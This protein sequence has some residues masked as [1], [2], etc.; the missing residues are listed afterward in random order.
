MRKDYDLALRLH[1]IEMQLASLGKKIADTNLAAGSEAYV[2]ALTLHKSI[3]AAVKVNIPGAKAFAAELD[4][5]FV[6]KGAAPE[7]PA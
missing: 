2:T 4:E 1:G 3:K 6:Q 7:G 5:R